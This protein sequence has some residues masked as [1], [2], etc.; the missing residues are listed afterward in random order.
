MKKLFTL[1]VA[2]FA[3]LSIASCTKKDP[4]VKPQNVR[5]ILFKL[6]TQKDFSDNDEDITFSIF[7]KK[8]NQTLFDSTL[9]TM[10]IK[11]IPKSASA[12][13]FEKKIN[14]NS[15]LSAGFNYSIENVGTSS[16]IDTIAAGEQNKE[17][18]FSFQ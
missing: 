11:D 18:D 2:I 1:C 3:I 17:I 10:K 12:M 5:S 13:I 4:T 8:A 7:I 15:L 14:D 16:H 6:Y 9:A